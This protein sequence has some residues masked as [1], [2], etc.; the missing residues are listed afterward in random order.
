MR[1]L[2][3]G[4]VRFDVLCTMLLLLIWCG[5]ASAF[6]FF[7]K[8]ANSGNSLRFPGFARTKQSGWLA[9]AWW[10][11]RTSLVGHTIFY[12]LISSQ[13]HWI[14]SQFSSLLNGIWTP[15]I[16]LLLLS[17]REV[18]QSPRYASLN[19]SFIEYFI[20]LNIINFAD[21]VRREN[22]RVSSDVKKINDI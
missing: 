16:I 12:R 21:I 2:C 7:K 10:R 5:S 17:S 3:G 13:K 8:N 1:C 14:N 11:I 4:G 6:Y 22:D 20:V 15:Y 9:V 18:L 19:G